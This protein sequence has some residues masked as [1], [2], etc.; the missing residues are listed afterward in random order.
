MARINFNV[1]GTMLII[2]ESVAA[3]ENNSLIIAQGC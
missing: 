2:R 1:L 3:L